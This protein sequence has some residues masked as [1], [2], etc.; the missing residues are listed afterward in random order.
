MK[1]RGTLRCG[2]YLLTA[3]AEGLDWAEVLPRGTSGMRSQ[4]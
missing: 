3:E 2:V 4:E 1:Q